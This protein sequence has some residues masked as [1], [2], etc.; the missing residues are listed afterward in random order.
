LLDA[1]RVPE[2]LRVHIFGDLRHVHTG[3]QEHGGERVVGQREIEAE[4]K[5]R[6]EGGTGR[7]KKM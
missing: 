1:G 6:K 3:T 2:A 4:G 7:Y 5:E